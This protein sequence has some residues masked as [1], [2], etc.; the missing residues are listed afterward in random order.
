[1]D[2]KTSYEE[3]VELNPCQLTIEEIKLDQDELNNDLLLVKLS[4]KNKEIDLECLVDIQS[5]LSFLK[6]KDDINLFKKTIECALNTV[7]F[8][9]E[10]R[11]NN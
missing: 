5:S 6:S 2:E 11:I 1:M 3:K 9:M 7:L 4:S 8:K 10:E